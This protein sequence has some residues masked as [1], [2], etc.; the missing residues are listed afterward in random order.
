MDFDESRIYL[1]G[2]DV[3]TIDWRVTARTGIAHTKVFR[4]ERERSVILVVEFSQSMFFGTRVA[5]KSVIAA[6]AAA[7]IG[8]AAINRGDR[9]GALLA[10]GSGHHELRPAGGRRGV[11]R[12]LNMVVEASHP[13]NGYG[14]DDGLD[15]ALVRTRRV[16]KPGSL[17]VVISDFYG[18][19]DEAQR[20]FMRLRA[21]ND[22]MACWIRDPLEQHAPPPGRY[23]ITDG[24]YRAVLDTA[25]VG[26]QRFE[27]LCQRR[28]ARVRTLIRE[29]GI[30]I[31]EI[32]TC[33]DVGDALQRGFAEPV[34]TGEARS[35]THA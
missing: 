22:V 27:G 11:L 32:N 2:D 25:R 31:V 34:Y 20:H 16:V 28:E 23:P 7:L 35:G 21:H 4:E 14:T 26:A 15:A 3:R 33:D 13:V 17:V 1:P 6:Q 19:D 9:V 8:W 24:R 12:L 29:R 5:F 18:L 30:P 10:S